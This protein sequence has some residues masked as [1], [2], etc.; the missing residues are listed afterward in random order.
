MHA[1][2]RHVAR[3]IGQHVHQ[4]RYG[5]TLI[6]AHIADARLQQRLGDRQN[7]LAA[8]FISVSQPQVFHFPCE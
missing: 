4:M 3:R 5:R 1:E 8:E 6:A 7:S 2:F